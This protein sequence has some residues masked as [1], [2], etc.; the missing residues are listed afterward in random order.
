MKRATGGEYHPPTGEEQLS[1]GRRVLCL[2]M[3]GLFVLLLVP[4]PL[5]PSLP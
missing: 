5:R 2:V 1:P 3:L 4:I